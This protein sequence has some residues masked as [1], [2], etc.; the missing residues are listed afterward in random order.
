LRKGRNEIVILDLEAGPSRS[1][2][3]IRELIFETPQTEQRDNS[4]QH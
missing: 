1:V 2:R 4:A 3:G